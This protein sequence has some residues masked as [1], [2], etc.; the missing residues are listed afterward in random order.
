MARFNYKRPTTIQELNQRTFDLEHYERLNYIRNRYRASSHTKKPE[1]R[2][3]IFQRDNYSCV[4]CG[5]SKDLTID[6]KVSVYRG[7]SDD[8]ENLQALCR[9]CNSRKAP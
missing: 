9:R 6:H 5:S 7:G 3:R 1:V 8:D 4:E 2:A